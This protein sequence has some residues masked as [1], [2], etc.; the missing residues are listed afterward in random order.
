MRIVQTFWSGGGDPLE[1]SYGWPHAVYNL[2]S[3]A[4]SCCSLRKYYDDV[5]LYTDRQG[6]EILIEKLHLPYTEVHVVYDGNICLPQHWALAKIKTYAMQTTPFLHVDG[7]IYVSKPFPENLFR[8]PLI[9]QN[10]EIGTIYYQKM[11]DA[12]M[13]IPNVWLPGYVCNALGGKLLPSYNMGVFGG[14]DIDFIHDYSREA[15]AFLDK[16]NMN[17]EGNPYSAVDCNVFFEQMIFAIY[18]KQRGREVMGIIPHAVRDNG[19][20]RDEFCDVIKFQEK[21]FFHVLGGHKRVLGICRSVADTLLVFYPKYYAAVVSV[22]KNSSCIYAFGT[23]SSYGSFLECKRREWKLINNQDLIL[24][25]TLHAKSIASF[26]ETHGMK[27]NLQVSLSPFL[28]LFSVGDNQHERECLRKQFRREEVFPMDKIALTPSLMFP[29]VNEFPL[30]EE[31]EKIISCLMCQS[32]PMTICELQEKVHGWH[33]GTNRKVKDRTYDY[34][35]EEISCM[36]SS[37]I[38]IAK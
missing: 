20:T 14:W 34:V 1:K 11:L 30:I 18:A 25:E 28:S 27:H 26:S 12:I 24:L 2:M 38:L 15:E 31:D 33:G 13:R 6:Y 22:I 3:W 4:L 37:R 5:V 32:T 23:G 35:M 36:I 21:G 19:Y 9:V 16:N 29:W 7:D 17:D 8:A 10:E